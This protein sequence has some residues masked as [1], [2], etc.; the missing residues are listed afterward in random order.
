M[1]I[2]RYIRLGCSAALSVTAVVGFALN[3]P[4]ANATLTLNPTHEVASVAG[5][6][7]DATLYVDT[8]FTGL[9][10]KI[11]WGQLITPVAQIVHPPCSG[12]TMTVFFSHVSGPGPS[13]GYTTFTAGLWADS[14]VRNLRAYVSAQAVF[15][16]DAP[17]PP[18]NGPGSTPPPPGQPG[19]PS[20][21][22]PSPSPPP[23]TP[24]ATPCPVLTAATNQGST[25]P[26]MSIP[27][28]GLVLMVAILLVWL[29]AAMLRRRATALL[30]L[31]LISA[32]TISCGRYTPPIAA[33][34]APSPTTSQ[35]APSPS[36]TC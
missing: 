36:P 14:D 24:T 12:Q 29:I 30:M 33:N 17:P 27:Q 21:V 4:A 35:L 25:N 15:R 16:M 31:I 1:L 7:L 23:V 28:S 18:P 3:A 13:P 2:R 34:E 8:C 32:L 22:V 20:T 5:N 11:F 10:A 26:A 9:T 19:P 6:Y